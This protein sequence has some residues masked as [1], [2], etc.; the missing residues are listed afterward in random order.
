MEPNDDLCLLVKRA[1][2]LQDFLATDDGENLVQG[3]K[4]AAN[5]LSAEEAR[6]GV[7][8]ELDPDPKLAKEE[9]ETVLFEAMSKAV[10]V[11]EA[12]LAEERFEEALT[13]L[14]NLRAPIDGFF[15]KVKVNAE[16]AILRRNR[17]C[18]LNQIREL[19][20]KFAKFD[21]LKGK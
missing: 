12:K 11:I 16:S 10:P 15:E 4:R 3:Y 1:R 20:E 21:A 7:S 19:S 9:A 18:L 13:S 6:D 5:I 8:Y 2:A 17:L 14:A